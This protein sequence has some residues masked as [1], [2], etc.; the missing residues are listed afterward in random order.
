VTITGPLGFSR[1]VDI[2]T[3]APPNERSRVN[4]VR[5]SL[6]RT[7]SY[8]YD[9]DLRVTRITY[10]EG[11]WAGVSYD[12]IGNI[13]E[14]RL[15]AK[16]GSGI[17]DIV[18]TAS[19]AS[20]GCIPGTGCICIQ[21]DCFKPQ[22]TQDA[23]GQQ[24]DYTWASHGGMLTRLEPVDAS[25]KRRKT[26]N[27]YSAGPVFRLLRE[28][29]CAT[30]VA[31][32]ELT[33]GTANEL[34]KEFTYWGSTLLPLTETVK[35]GTGGQART[36]TFTYDAAG[37]LLS[38][39]GPTA[40]TDDAT[41]NRY[42]TAGRKTWEIGPKG[43]NG[44]RAA[45]RTIYRDADNQ[46]LTIEKGTIV[47]DTDTVLTVV[48][49]QYLTYNTR[50]KVIKQRTA[51]G[52]SDL[53]VSQM[54]YDARNRDQC[55]AVRMNSA[56]WASLPADACTLGT[57]GTQG[58]DRITRTNYDAES[59]VIL[60]EKAV[61]TS[62][63]QDYAAYTYTVNGKKEFTT[64]ANGNKAKFQYDGHD[65][66]THWWFPSKTTVGT[67]STTDYEQ[68]GYDANG[69]R[70][71]LRKRDGS[72]LC[73][74]YDALNRVISKTMGPACGDSGGG[75]TN[76]PPVAINDSTPATRCQVRTVNVTSN[77]TDPDGDSL[78]VISA[79]SGTME[80]SAAPPSS[81]NFTVPDQAGTFVVNY[82]IS[83][84]R[85]G[86]DTAS[87]TVTVPSTPLCP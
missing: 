11:N 82:T 37:R 56:A 18:E 63:E 24:T 16:A 65:R 66:Q 31:G 74:A 68:Y 43:A 45:T 81:V 55:T 38:S 35:D 23:K 80:A 75:G 54:S 36:T 50:R 20:S 28:R 85:G 73:Y 84:G 13:T 64:D 83:D 25:G 69:N 61:G 79:S 1:F 72:T 29:V 14:S 44:Y 78:I 8:L 10:P 15:M 86:T 47:N 19:F 17:A 5:D 87:L 22:W 51:A 2:Y 77:D 57:A 70:T 46:P 62:R 52:G 32:V 4:S 27:E 39:D 40:G 21:A 7:T 71:S 49:T 48:N 42:D 67:V 58:A 59:R 34:V 6:N 26:I 41:Y 76:Q 53:A 30:D 9:N 60:I 33:C 3:P 12:G